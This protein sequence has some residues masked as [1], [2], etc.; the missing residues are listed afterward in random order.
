MPRKPV[1]LTATAARPQGRDVIWAAI[2]KLGTFTTLDL[3]GETH[4]KEATI[5]T[6]VMGLERA[7]YLQRIDN[8]PGRIPGA[9]RAARWKLSNDVGVE[10][11]RV[12]RQGKPVTQGGAREQMWRTMRILGTFT[13][14]DLAIQ[15]STETQPVAE[16]DAKSYCRYLD[17]AGYLRLTE[18][19]GPGKLN[20]YRFI[21]AR[22]TGPKP[23]M[24]QRVRQVF[25]PNLNQVVW[26][27]GGDE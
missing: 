16:D 23:P 18:K 25:D 6:Y 22:Y 26:T 24:V 20:V 5:R 27:A 1:H 12:T 17:R 21:T 15:A 8:A 14:R 11:P 19:G 13:Y 3:E 2:R 7:G 4:V 9:I 10:A